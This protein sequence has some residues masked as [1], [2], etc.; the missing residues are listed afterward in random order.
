MRSDGN[1]RPDQKTYGL[2]FSR[3]NDDAGNKKD[4]NENS[5]SGSRYVPR[6]SRSKTL[7]TKS[8]DS[9]DPSRSYAQTSRLKGQIGNKQDSRLG[10]IAEADNKKS[11]QVTKTKNGDGSDSSFSSRQQSS[12]Q[13]QPPAYGQE[14][15]ALGLINSQN[16]RP[17]EN[18]RA[19]S[20][21]S[22]EG[23]SDVR[24]ELDALSRAARIERYKEERRKELQGSLG[25]SKE[26]SLPET[27]LSGSLPRTQSKEENPVNL[28]ITDLL[29]LRRARLRQQRHIVDHEGTK[30]LYDIPGGGGG[31]DSNKENNN[32]DLRVS[33]VVSSPTEIRQFELPKASHLARHRAQLERH[34]S[35]SDTES[36]NLR[37]VKRSPRPT[38]RVP[39]STLYAEEPIK[40]PRSNNDDNKSKPISINTEPGRT[41][42]HKPHV[43]PTD[44]TT[45]KAEFNIRRLKKEWSSESS[46]MSLTAAADANQSAAG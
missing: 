43:T 8:S 18:V 21:S 12:R 37:T 13:W 16:G 34:D 15:E 33:E 28:G 27:E 30:I 10:Q 45:A 17:G 3:K 23:G 2:R 24:S 26:G 1:R 22:I 9:D 6:Y 14:S 7:P 41:G 40:K 20:V 39:R 19:D 44:L 42:G 11:Y 38:R 35:S 46:N 25:S 29:S 4:S 32:T 31:R 36:E 5:V